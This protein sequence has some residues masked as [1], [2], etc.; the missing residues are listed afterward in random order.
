MSKNKEAVKPWWHSK[1][2]IMG[3]GIAVAGIIFL[4]AGR[5]EIGWVL[6]G[7]GSQQVGL[8]AVTSTPIVPTLKGGK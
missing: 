7:L 4:V 6:F 5:D 2:V 8:R 1:T 3:M